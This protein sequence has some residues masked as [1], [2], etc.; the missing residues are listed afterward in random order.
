MCVLIFIEISTSPLF[1][2]TVII[3]YRV[4]LPRA[5]SGLDLHHSITV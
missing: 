3:K 2:L 4:L 1:F 5:G